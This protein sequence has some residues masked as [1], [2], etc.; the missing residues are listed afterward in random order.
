MNADP[1]FQPLAAAWLDGTAT[2]PEQKLLGEILHGP[3]TMREYAALCRTEALLAQSGTTAS[4][5]RAVL[6]RMLAGKPWSRRMVSMGNCRAFRWAAAAALV[7]LGVW[8]L[9]PNNAEVEVT[10]KRK[11]LIPPRVAETSQGN[12]SRPAALDEAPLPAAAEGL[13]QR[14]RRQYISGF[15]TSAPLPEAAAALVRAIH[16]GREMKLTADVRYEGDAPVHLHLR[17]SLPA[18]D[19]LQIMALQ[20]GTEV[21]LSDQTLVFLEA[22]KPAPLTGRLTRTSELNPLRTL[23]GIMEKDSHADEL[24]TFSERIETALGGRLGFAGASESSAKYSGIPRDVR[25]LDLALN[26]IN[27]P[28]VTIH[29]AMRLV[30]VAP[31]A[32]APDGTPLDTGKL[33]PSLSGIFTDA[34]FQLMMRSLS[35]Q[36]GVDLMTLPAVTAR[37]NAEV[38]IEVNP[39]K[40]GLVALLLASPDEDGTCNLHCEMGWGIGLP[41]QGLRDGN[42]LVNTQ[43]LLFSGQTLGLSGFRSKEGSEILA[44][45]TATLVQPD[46]TPLPPL[47][48]A[49]HPPDTSDT[50]KPQENAPVQQVELPYGIPVP[51]KKGMVQSPYAPEQGFIDVDGYNRGTRVECPYT[52]KHF[53]VP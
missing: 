12:H 48:K 23:C 31:G 22:K 41:G 30:E 10:A 1:D 6:G 53:R 19:L 49:P 50:I 33:S 29:L 16:P 43:V 17:P 37:P 45:I 5:R 46:G 27:H 42:G 11:P 21:H 9:W 7:A 35:M 39:G 34:Q 26:S 28:T 36:K 47:D 13:E 25:V 32:E 20:S 51:D 4:Q 52:G 40:R 8:W 2:P 38:K 44:F 14:L 15:Q 24:N 3:D 18:W